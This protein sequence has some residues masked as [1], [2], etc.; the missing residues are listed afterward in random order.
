[1]A[2]GGILSFFGNINEVNIIVCTLVRIFM[3]VIVLQEEC[4][5]HN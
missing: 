4:I 3:H 1:M 5:Q 2:S